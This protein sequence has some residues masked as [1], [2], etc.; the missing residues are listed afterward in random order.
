MKKDGASDE[1]F[2]YGSGMKEEE[3]ERER[4]K[5]RWK[6]CIQTDMKE[7][8]LNTDNAGDKYKGENTPKTETV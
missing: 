2:G 6:D 3:R 4:P 8:G 1:S 5:I 7:K